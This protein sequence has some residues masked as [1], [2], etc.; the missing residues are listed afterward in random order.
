MDHNIGYEN[1]LKESQ[2]IISNQKLF[3]APTYYI[4]ITLILF[5]YAPKAKKLVIDLQK[6]M[7]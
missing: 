4:V 1:Q 2:R 3:A 6:L 7:I 5:L